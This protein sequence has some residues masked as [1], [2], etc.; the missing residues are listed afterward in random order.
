MKILIFFI[1]LFHLSFLFLPF[2]LKFLQLN[3]NSFLFKLIIL[4]YLL[5]P[6]HWKIFNNNCLFTLLSHKLG[7][8]KNTKTNSKFSEKYLKWLYNPLIK[9]F[10]TNKNWNNKNLNKIIN[11]HWVL[12]F[13]IVWYYIFF[14]YCF[15]KN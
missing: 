9:F 14:K 7:D 12:N 2:N 8:F 6:L 5:T 10:F 15:I 13:I 3:L 11:Y 4:F 1:N